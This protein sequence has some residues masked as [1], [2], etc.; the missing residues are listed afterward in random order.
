MLLGPWRKMRRLGLG[1]GVGGP[2][3]RS[4]DG[5]EL[6]PVYTGTVRAQHSAA[7]GTRQAS[8]P[9]EMAAVKKALLVPIR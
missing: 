9:V 6:T 2:S 4:G 5:E 1:F 3:G 8:D 7:A